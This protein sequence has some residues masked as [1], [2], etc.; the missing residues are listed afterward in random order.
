MVNKMEE[1]Q[2]GENVKVVVRLRPLNS[3]E[4]DSKYKMI[5]KVNTIDGTIKVEQPKKDASAM[6]FTFDK[7]FPLDVKQVDVYN[8]VARSIVNNV[9]EGYNGTLPM[10]QTGT[11]KTFTMEGDRT[12]QRII[13]NSFAHIF[14]RIAKYGDKKNFRKRI[15]RK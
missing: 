14:C 2:G 13:P 6:C 11:G 1:G 12:V 8:R 5:T 4:L 3:K 10:K 15:K 7:V 9:L